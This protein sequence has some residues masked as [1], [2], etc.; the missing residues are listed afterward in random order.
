MA[1][2]SLEGPKDLW[3]AV[4]VADCCQAP[5]VWMCCSEQQMGITLILTPSFSLIHLLTRELFAVRRPDARHCRKPG[6]IVVSRT[7]ALA[8]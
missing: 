2:S 6:D 5:A 1:L 7:E 4:T 3:E 8:C